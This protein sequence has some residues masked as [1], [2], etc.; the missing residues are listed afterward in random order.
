MSLRQGLSAR[1]TF[2]HMLR[3]GG[4]TEQAIDFLQETARKYPA[5]PLPW[6]ILA[7]FWR[8]LGRTDRGEQACRQ[9]IKVDPEAVQG[10]YG[11]GCFQLPNRPEE[12]MASFRRALDLKP[13]HALA[14][15]NLGLCL[16]RLGDLSGAEAELRSALRCRPDLPE[17]RA[18]LE[19]VTKKEK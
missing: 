17:A 4:N 15:L 12:A 13:D 8:D 9:A 5:S 1:L 10:W 6:L 19:E 18:A 16:K 7:E 14:H 2:A 3:R 11:L